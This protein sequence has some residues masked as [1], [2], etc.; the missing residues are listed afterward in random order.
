MTNYTNYEANCIKSV[1]QELK[2]A[3]EHAEAKLLEEEAGFQP[4]HKVTPKPVQNNKILLGAWLKN[5]VKSELGTE[6]LNRPL[7]RSIQKEL[8]KKQIGEVTVGEAEKV[9][10][11][12]KNGGLYE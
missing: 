2:D 9:F 6:A 12:I 10:Q 1:I 4:K 5:K 8:V 11:I 3:N 7:Y